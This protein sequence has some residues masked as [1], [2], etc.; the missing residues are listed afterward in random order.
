MII[1][2]VEH[3][4]DK[5]EAMLS[6][7]ASI[8]RVDIDSPLAR[9]LYEEWV[10]HVGTKA[11]QEGFY[12]DFKLS[13]LYDYAGER[14]LLYDIYGDN[15]GNSFIRIDEA[16]TGSSGDSILFGYEPPYGGDFLMLYGISP[17]FRS[18]HHR[19]GE[20]IDSPIVWLIANQKGFYLVTP[21][22]DEFYSHL[23]YVVGEEELREIL[24]KEIGSEEMKDDL[25]NMISMKHL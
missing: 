11:H 21:I 18:K 5:E 12:V 4:T 10:N 25:N 14:S 22:T 20:P 13:A 19:V 2:S 23:K 1:E 8:I 3:F 15:A 24:S 17:R 6:F 9:S 7:C 16:V